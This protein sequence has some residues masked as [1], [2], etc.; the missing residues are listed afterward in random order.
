[1]RDRSERKP[2]GA[3]GSEKRQRDYIVTVR[4]NGAER[5]E[6]THRADRAGLSIPAYFRH[7]ALDIAP[8]RQRPR[9][10]VEVTVLARLL[11]QIGQIGSDVRAMTD[12]AQQTTYVPDH[13]LRMLEA[14]YGDLSRLGAALLLAMGRNA[15]VETER[16]D[17]H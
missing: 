3:S 4:L 12:L 5:S 1:M 9:P 8:P 16:G 11:G 7:Q 14:L 17:D 10:V 6:L 13:D 15:E 2:G